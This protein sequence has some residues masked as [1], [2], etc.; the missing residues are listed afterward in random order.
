MFAFDARARGSASFDLKPGQQVKAMYVDLNITPA[1]KRGVLYL[2]VHR[3]CLQLSDCFVA[4]METVAS[5][6]ISAPSQ[7]D[8]STRIISIGQLWEVLYRRLPASIPASVTCALPEPHDYLWGRLCRKR[9]WEPGDGPEDGEVRPWPSSSLFRSN[10]PT[11][12]PVHS[13]WSTTQ[14]RSQT[15]PLQS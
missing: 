13:Y 10:H 14:Y 1:A 12:T 9:S 5:T 11:I 8:L 2:P 15:S 4:W 6:S 3:I 7:E